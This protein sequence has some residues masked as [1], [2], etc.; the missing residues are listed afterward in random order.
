[1]EKFF[2]YLGHKAG[3]SIRKGKWIYHSLFADKEQA[4]ESEYLV[5]K[6]L[7][8]KV[9]SEYQV[10]DNSGTRPLI[11]EI[12]KRLTDCLTNKKRT[13]TFLISAQERHRLI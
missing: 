6:E 8:L 3:P 4:I 5:G 13:K 10:F 11:K 12:H 7:A 1:M 2:R 9:L